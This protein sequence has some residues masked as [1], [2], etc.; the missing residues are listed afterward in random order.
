MEEHKERLIRFGSA[1]FEALCSFKIKVINLAENGADDLMGEPVA[2]LTSCA[3]R[4]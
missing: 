3:T 4:L 1:W 2:I